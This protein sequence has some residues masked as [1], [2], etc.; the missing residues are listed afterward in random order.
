MNEYFFSPQYSAGKYLLLL[1]VSKKII[2]S[3]S[4]IHQHF[5]TLITID[6]SILKR[7]QVHIK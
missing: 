5:F 6:L 2:Q 3:N 4:Q 7:N 1:L